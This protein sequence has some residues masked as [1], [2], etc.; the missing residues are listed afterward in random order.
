MMFL[1]PSKINIS[2]LVQATSVT[3]RKSV[4]IDVIAIVWGFTTYI[5][6]S[7]YVTN[8]SSQNGK[9]TPNVGSPRFFLELSGAGFRSST[10][11]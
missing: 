7:L 6:S 4:I 5:I 3:R 10:S 9:I 2:S 8:K 1:S 11:V